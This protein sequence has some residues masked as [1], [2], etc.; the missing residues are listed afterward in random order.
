MYFFYQI[1]DYINFLFLENFFISFII[2]SIIFLIYS[3]LSL[4]GLFLLWIFSGFIYGTIYGYIISVIYTSLGFIII[5]ILSKT[6]FK[7]FFNN[8]F[9]SYLNKI[10]KIVGSNSYEVLILFRMW[11]INFPYFI[12]NIS[13]SF[14]KISTMK[15]I[16]TTIIGLAPIMIFCCIFGSTLKELKELKEVN[17]YNILSHNLILLLLAIMI[18]LIAMIIIRRKYLK[19]FL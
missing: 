8:K 16:I 11:P 19:D 12:Q 14:F 1:L 4:P 18:F 9:N 10:E 2:F 3:I 13:L 15:Y 6:L 7:N 17:I 5:F